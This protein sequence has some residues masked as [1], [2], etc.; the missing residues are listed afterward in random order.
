ME[1]NPGAVRVGRVG[2]RPAGPCGC[3]LDILRETNEARPKDGN[4]P[5]DDDE[6]HLGQ[7]PDV[8]LA[9]GTGADKLGVLGNGNRLVE[10]GDPRSVGVRCYRLM[11]SGVE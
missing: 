1:F 6:P 11:M 9:G 2:G 5:E 7:G 8:D 10:S 4:R 3:L